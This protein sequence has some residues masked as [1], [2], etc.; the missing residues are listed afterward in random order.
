MCH[1]TH[2]VVSNSFDWHVT[3][4]I[5]EQMRWLTTPSKLSIKP[6]KTTR[7]M[8]LLTKLE[9]TWHSTCILSAHTCLV[10]HIARS[11]LLTKHAL[12][13]STQA[14]ALHSVHAPCLGLQRVLY[15]C[16]NVTELGC[17]EEEWA[18]LPCPQRKHRLLQGD[19]RVSISKAS[20][21]AHFCTIWLYTTL[22]CRVRG[23]YSVQPIALLYIFNGVRLLCLKLARH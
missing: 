1:S 4:R 10:C 5:L 2:Q 7:L 22:P 20:L 11:V 6:S 3:H 16:N 15:R 9:V 21:H 13:T 12:L 8:L 17:A 23:W 18:H 19:C 14:L